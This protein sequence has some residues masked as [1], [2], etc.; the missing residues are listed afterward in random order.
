M[1]DEDAAVRRHAMHHRASESHAAN[2]MESD[3][4]FIRRMMA[5][6]ERSTLPPSAH[7]LRVTRGQAPPKGGASPLHARLF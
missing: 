4:G 5:T 1:A 2:S 6:S 3:A 7:P